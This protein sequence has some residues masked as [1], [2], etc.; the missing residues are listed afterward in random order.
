MA[1]RYAQG[2]P[3]KA[4]YWL[5]GDVDGG[6][7]EADS[8]KVDEAAQQGWTTVPL[9]TLHDAERAVES[10]RARLL[11]MQDGI[12]AACEALD[13]ARAE[14]DRL[15]GWKDEALPVIAGLQDLGRALGL[16]LGTRITGPEAVDAALDLRNAHDAATTR[17]DALVADREYWRTRL[18]R[19]VTALQHL[20][21]DEWL[22]TRDRLMDLPGTRYMRK[23]PAGHIEHAAYEIRR[24]IEGLPG[25]DPVGS[26]GA[27]L[28]WMRRGRD[29]ITKSGGTR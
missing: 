18:E 25:Y 28:R 27:Y 29:R 22:R 24:L 26:G 14:R 11:G 10:E 16:R 4:T 23:N 21:D 2:A 1:S 6:H 9:V 5:V 15:S 12:N 3:V 17:T 13:E 20:C 8:R 7:I 19:L